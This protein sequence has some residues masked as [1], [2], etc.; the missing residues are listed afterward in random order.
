[1]R[2]YR[3]KRYENKRARKVFF[4][5][6][7]V[8]MAAVLITVGATLL[9][10]YVKKLVE[11]A[12]REIASADVTP[13]PAETSGGKGYYTTGLHEIPATVS[14]LAVDPF[15]EAELATL[16][17]DLK[18]SFDAA[19]V[20][21]TDDGTLVYLSPSRLSY[22]GLPSA[23]LPENG[24]STGFEQLKAF[25]TAV[26]TENLRMCAVMEA[27]RESGKADGALLPAADKAILPELAGLGFDEVI[28]TG[29][30]ALTDEVDEYLTSLV[31][32]MIPVGA[33]FS[34]DDYMD[35]RNEKRFRILS[36]AGVLLCVDL[37]TDDEA[38]IAYATEERYFD[39]RN[40]DSVYHLYYVL[41]SE[42]SAV[43]TEQ[44]TALR[45]VKAD[46]VLV[47]SAVSPATLSGDSAV[48]ETDAAETAPPP[49]TGSPVN[50]YATTG[51]D[52]PEE[53]AP[54]DETSAPDDGVYRG[55]DSWW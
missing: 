28:F 31:N 30:G 7:F 3:R 52:Y 16:L 37:D 53:T 48:G 9:G 36:A 54:R 12:E 33:V 26:K 15:G 10:H 14:A 23:E 51:G 45:E 42:D 2:Y 49:E 43:L 4:R 27:T 22:I 17:S 24:T 44:Y 46:R 21:L 41:D 47:A 34:Y 20:K 29:L 40:A 18:Q 50:P 55:E 19:A 8:L 5:I 38:E 32:D 11:E 6:F 35:P 1:M 13:D 25:G 39:L